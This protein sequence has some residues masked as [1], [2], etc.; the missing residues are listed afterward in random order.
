MESI[1]YKEVIE[2]KIV[3]TLGKHICGTI[4]SVIEN[5][6]LGYRYFPKGATF[7]GGFHKTLSDCKLSLEEEI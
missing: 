6:E 4:W 1:K 2:G 7:G 5:G 3:V